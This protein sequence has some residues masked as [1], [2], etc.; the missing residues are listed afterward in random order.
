VLT[1]FG[2]ED[3]GAGW[4]AAILELTARAF[5]VGMPE[6]QRAEARLRATHRYLDTMLRARAYELGNAFGWGAT[7]AREALESLVSRG[8]AIRAGNA[9]TLA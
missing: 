3:Q 8:D 7:A 5:R 9:Y 2:V 6:G 1:N 4:P